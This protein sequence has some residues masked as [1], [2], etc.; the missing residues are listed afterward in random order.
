MSYGDRHYHFSYEPIRT[1]D[2]LVGLLLVV[3]DVTDA[4]KRA[5][6]DAEQ[7]EQLAIARWLSHDRESLLG[8]FEEGRAL[9]E[10]VSGDGA[11]TDD[12]RAPLHTLKGNAGMLGF[13]VLARLCH[14][15][16]NAIEAGTFGRQSVLELTQ[17]W[18]A[19]ETS[20]DLLLGHD[21][22]N[23]I[24][25]PRSEL[26]ALIA[27]LRAGACVDD[28][29]EALECF[30]LQP[31]SRPL[32]HLGERA[33]ELCGRSFRKELAISVD[34]GGLLG[35]T[36]EGSRLW[37]ALV[38]LVRN[39]VD[40]GIEPPE[41]RRTLGKPL[42]ATLEFRANLDGDCAVI[43]IADDGRGIDWERV[44]VR[45]QERGLPRSS[46]AD[47]VEALFAPSLSLRDDV[48]AISGRGIGLGAVRG[49]VEALGGSIELESEPGRGCRFRVRVPAQTLGVRSGTP[50]ADGRASSPAPGRPSRPRSPAAH[51]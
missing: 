42:P 27:R 15:A 30:E 17:R 26:S 4:L 44:Q 45:A 29:I 36:R 14:E 33:L 43:E 48:T 46:R 31:L 19:L 7:K 34:D 38:H 3:G 8:F 11:S 41:E 28:A 20:L 49:E 2:A 37:A 22:R 13:E 1:G 24:E 32:G 47:L 6:A 35:D 23:R 51:P 9:L 21:G 25:V 10:R 12:V 16:E 5:E 18:G 40:H 39:A 50:K